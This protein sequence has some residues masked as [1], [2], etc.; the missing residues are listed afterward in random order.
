MKRSFA[1]FLVVLLALFMHVPQAN[2]Y[3]LLVADGEVTNGNVPLSG[4][5]VDNN[6]HHTQI[7]YPEDMVA[8]LR[9]S[10]IQQLQ[11][12]SPNLESHNWNTV[13]TVKLAVCNNA[14]FSTT[15]FLTSA[16][17]AFF[18]VYVGGLSNVNSMLTIDFDEEFFYDGGN[19]LVDLSCSSGGTFAFSSFYGITSANASINGYGASAPS[20]GNRY[21][22]IPKTTFTYESIPECYHA[23]NIQADSLTATSAFITWIS[24]NAEDAH[25]NLECR[26]V[27]DDQIIVS[28][29]GLDR[30]SYSISGLLP[31]T[32]YKVRIQ[33]DCG[34]LQTDWS[35]FVTFRTECAALTELPYNQ[36]F[37]EGGAGTTA[38]PLP[39][40]WTRFNDAIPSSVGAH[41]PCNYSGNAYAGSSVLVFYTSPGANYANHQVAVF[42]EIDVDVNP[43]NTL[44]IDFW[45][46][47]GSLFYSDVPLVVGVMSD[48]TDLATFVPVETL[49]VNDTNYEEFTVSLVRYA[50]Q[51]T[52]PAIRL[53][54]QPASCQ[55]F[56][57][58]VTVEAVPN[59]LRPTDVRVSDVSNNSVILSWT[60]GGNE[61]AWNIAY[62]FADDDN[63][64][65][66]I[67]PVNTRSYTLA[68]LASNT[69]YELKIQSDCGG[70]E[71]G[72]TNVIKFTTECDVYMLSE[73][74]PYYEGFEDLAA[75]PDCWKNIHNVGSSTVVWGIGSIAHSGSNALNLPLMSSGNRVL[76]ILPCV[77]VPEDGDY[78]ID[79][80]YN[81]IQS[82]LG[83]SAEA[84]RILVDTIP[85][86]TN[87]YEL[88][89]VN[90]AINRAPVA[91]SAGWYH[92][93]AVIPMSGNLYIM[94]EGISGNL[95][96]QQID[97]ITIKK[98]P[99][100]FPVAELY[101]TNVGRREFTA[102]WTPS[103]HIANVE[104]YQLVNSLTALTNAQL[105]A[106][107]Y[108]SVADG[109]HSYHFTDLYRDTTY[110]FYIRANCGADDG[111]GNWRS[112]DVRTEAPL[113]DPCPQIAGF[114]LDTVSVN[115][116]QFSWMASTADYVRDYNFH[117]S[118]EQLT[119]EELNHLGSYTYTGYATSYSTNELVEFTNY[120]AYVRVNCTDGDVDDGSSV[121]TM[122]PF[123]TQSVCTAPEY[124]TID[125]LGKYSMFIRWTMPSY[126]D[127]TSTYDV[128][129][130]T[131][132]G[133]QVFAQDNLAPITRG[134]KVNDLMRN[135]LYSVYVR[136][137]C[138]GDEHSGWANVSV[139]TDD[140][141][142]DPCPALRVAPVCSDT[143][144]NSALISWDAAEGD[145]ANTY[146]LYLSN[147]PMTTNP[148]VEDI[149]T[150]IDSLSY[151][152]TGLTG[153]NYYAYVRVKCDKGIYDDGI[154]GWSP[155]CNFE[156]EPSC[157][158]PYGLSYSHVTSNSVA[159]QWLDVNGAE[160]WDVEMTEFVR[161]GSTVDTIVTFVPVFGVKYG[162]NDSIAPDTVRYLLTD[163]DA[164]TNYSV[165]VRTQC[166]DEGAS[167]WGNNV[168]T[169]TTMSNNSALDSVGI[170][171]QKSDLPVVSYTHEGDNF[172]IVLR[173]DASLENVYIDVFK[174]DNGATIKVNGNTYSR[175][176]PIEFFDDAP[177]LFTV[178]AQDTNFRHDYYV[179]V[180]HESCA[181]PFDVTATKVGR[182][183][184]T[185]TWN[186]A[187]TGFQ[188]YDYV[189]SYAEMDDAALAAVTPVSFSDSTLVLDIV[190]ERDT[191]CYFYMR[192]NCGDAQSHWGFTSFHTLPLQGCDVAEIGDMTVDVSSIP[193]S[194][195]S[196]YGTS[197][198]LYTAD[199]IGV[200][201][202]FTSISYEYRRASSTPSRNVR[203]YLAET[204]ASSLSAISQWPLVS[205]V[206]KV[207]DGTFTFQYGWNEI[208][209]TRSFSFSG[210]KNLVVVF[211][212]NTGVNDGPNRWFGT[213]PCNS[214]E[215]LYKNSDKNNIDP[216]TMTSPSA[217]ISLGYKNKVR[218]AYCFDA[219]SCPEVE[220]IYVTDYQST[221][222][223]LAWTP[224][225]DYPGTYDLYVSQ[226][227]V[228]DFSEVVPTMT[229]PGTS[230]IV[231]GLSPLTHY[232]VYVRTNCERGDG[233]SNWAEGEFTTQADCY[234]P[235]S[236]SSAAIGKH[237]AHVAW[238]PGT[239]RQ[240]YDFAYIISTTPIP[241]DSFLD[242]MTPTARGIESDYV[243]L[244]GLA[245]ST[246][247]FFYVHNDCG[248]VGC[249]PWVGTM[250]TI[251][252]QQPQ[253][254]N[255]HAS[256][257]AHNS[258]VVSWERDSL[259]F[260]TETEWQIAWTLTGNA[261]TNWINVTETSRMLF[262]LDAETGY[263]F[264]VRPF[265]NGVAG[266]LA[267]IDVTTLV[268]PGNCN[269]FIVGTSML[270]NVPIYSA[271]KGSYSVQIYT[272]D[273]LIAQGYSAGEI[274]SVG[275]YQ[276]YCDDSQDVSVYQKTT[277]LWMANTDKVSF[278][279][280]YDWITSGLT[281]VMSPRPV[282]FNVVNDW[283]EMPLDEPFAWDGTSNLAVA[284]LAYG[285][286]LS[287][288]GFSGCEV[289]TLARSIFAFSD[290]P[291]WS[292]M[293]G[294][295][296]M[297]HSDT[298]SSRANIKLCFPLPA[299]FAPNS[300]VA[301]NI[302]STSAE[303]TWHP[304]GF[305]TEWEYVYS[306][307]PMTDDALNTL[308]ATEVT[309]PAVTLSDLAND[310]DV[311]IYVRSN[312]G[313][314]DYSTW[315]ELTFHTLEYCS[316]LVADEATVFNCELPY[317]WRGRN[318]TVAGVYFDTLQT[319][320]GCDSI[321]KLTLT[322]MPNYLDVE[323]VTANGAKL[324]Y[325]WHG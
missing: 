155:V 89:Y 122:L 34:D 118:T 291:S 49:L 172:E 221:E 288:L 251:P 302:T 14:S 159:L 286:K 307:S 96:A 261:P 265:E 92:C 13:W 67:V 31:N 152:V 314:D 188:T 2:A 27:D 16:D 66:T 255:L 10:M 179:F 112:I 63:A 306:Y 117:I 244:T 243:D 1:L 272:A 170:Y 126:T 276:T 285:E 204:D 77:H 201:A 157:L 246:D 292:V 192:H 169:F 143:T 79:L 227:K 258:F 233:M 101:P 147:V 154:S 38:N 219:E 80:W 30:M 140:I 141:I 304:G 283:V 247:Y 28:A 86:V 211:D 209:F 194:F 60:A 120:Y 275:L 260:A 55:C 111:M 25:Y 56:V 72:W 103:S 264:Y 176:T 173:A 208:Q 309:Y 161:H 150:G 6:Y 78:M 248:I 133:I 40:C 222:V 274:L 19:L 322:V 52:Y 65:W 310:T 263:T 109:V 41:Y 181:T 127:P 35:S 82:S 46:K 114:K 45:A 197:I 4:F 76:A 160:A 311:F 174:H 61:R 252:Y 81:R 24:N 153:G 289:D 32:G 210:D 57:D 253:V 183:N 237:S 33:S 225:A 84:I 190:A 51:G 3:G 36:G 129:V 270:S 318:L 58:D 195:Y 156:I 39:Y 220:D 277:A 203:I 110:H 295:P 323:D 301:D 135:T 186:I 90:H 294:V 158:R 224:T 54:R 23:T 308:P 116:A 229:V 134:V 315:S 178:I 234:A 299:C 177:V 18:T 205:E 180:H 226:T 7:I 125:S 206:N 290:G 62:K 259:N 269:E 185:I 69:T 26:K 293:D 245:S 196:K 139:T 17:V 271:Y 107:T 100:C 235:L 85:D 73:Q 199:E 59:C 97:D 230:A 93:E 132:D 68:G 83:G 313:G 47:K 175:N 163:L 104:G 95:A 128:K 145:W 48:P 137:N 273:E 298:T 262:G 240:A 9:G 282:D 189:L 71:S 88:L 42:P 102:N 317:F 11:F 131:A 162:A 164:K 218:F 105:A 148:A 321:F 281:Q 165:R 202:D 187:A 257:I 149:I 53:D 64:D 121:W 91:S 279:D 212:D 242:L 5:N 254:I 50:G 166:G 296:L 70:V 108:I 22:F 98:V 320:A 94:I 267:T 37:E 213:Y 236:I 119:D 312:C 297:S 303:I 142:G 249:S 146:E 325:I 231:T 43:M 215:V 200:S 266:N 182:R 287:V 198:Q 21:N 305:E 151:L 223:T 113:A 241:S 29:N 250:F 268:D 123:R 232:Y 278:A 214:D 99:V 115:H 324:P 130:E 184:V 217:L 8:G 124:V 207:F 191:M 171:K 228:D 20:S 12:Y 216:T 239:D 138:G 316:F 300:V 193:S 280:R 87:A 319:V 106:A 44:R 136:A 256:D 167:Y 74:N 238:V 144:K 75:T 15:S 168:V 284:M